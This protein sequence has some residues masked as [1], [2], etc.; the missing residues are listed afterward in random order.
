V[1]GELIAAGGV[2]APVDV[3]AAVGAGADAVVV[4]RALYEEGQLRVA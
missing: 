2:Y 3:T 1:P 4:G